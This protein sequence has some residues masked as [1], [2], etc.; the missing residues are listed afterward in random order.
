M[1]L[2]RIILV[3]FKAYMRS[4]CS[5]TIGDFSG[6]TVK[7]I[8]Q[9]FHARAFM[10]NMATMIRTQGN[11]KMDNDKSGR[12]HKVQPNKTQVL[13]KTNDFLIDISTQKK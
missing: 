1:K 11:N 10:L 9:D 3:R 6:K 8:K 2:Q 12:K 7:A 4:C 5:S 13:A